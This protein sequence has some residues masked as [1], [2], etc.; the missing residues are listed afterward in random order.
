MQRSSPIHSMPVG[1]KAIVL[2]TLS[3]A[4]STAFAH[5][6][7]DAAGGLLA[8]FGHPFGGLDHLLVML[9]VGIWS[10]MLARRAWPDLL[11]APLGFT[12]MLL[13]GVVI[14][15]GGGSVPLVEPVI[16]A[17]VVVVGLLIAT[18]ARMPVA[19]A[20]LLVGAFALFHGL[21]HGEHF[22]AAPTGTWS[23]VAGLT[24]AT[25]MLHL[26]GVAIGLALRTAPRAGW[27]RLVGVG[28]AVAGAWILAVPV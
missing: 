9:G 6:G 7:H 16:A 11:W 18:Q 10:A 15:I 14:G 27:M 12:A 3:A 17:S 2:L 23:A 13:A 1:P 22:G 19:A 24:L 25:V 8:G 28:V 20:A 4:C 5:P 26:I 21:V